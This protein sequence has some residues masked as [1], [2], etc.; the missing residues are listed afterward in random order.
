MDATV[1]L[2]EWAGALVAR[3]GGEPESALLAADSFLVDGGRVVAPDLHRHRFMES[4]RRQGFGDVSELTRFW[5][6]AIAALP[7]A[8]RWFPRFELARTG[9]IVSLR[10]R[11]R[12]APSRGGALVVATAAGD[13]RR[14][15]GVKG[16]DID[17]LSVV[18]RRAEQCGAQEAV[19][20]DRGRVADGTAT[21]LLWWRGRTL[22]AP[23]RTIPRVDSVTAR[24]LGGIAAELGITVE[25]EDARPAELDGSVLW[26]VNA[27]HGIRE[28]AGWA[29]GPELRRDPPRAAVWQSRLAALATP[30]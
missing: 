17:R 20:L 15:P 30:V 13:P 2:Y 21:A 1:I 26:A 28:V 19:I 7:A 25:E 18:R 24:A 5:T 3:E 12:P 29:D 11:V 8:G 10:L 6:A 22:C 27:L 4:A 14:F 23:P 9:E 16:P